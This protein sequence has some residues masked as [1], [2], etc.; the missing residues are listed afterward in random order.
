MQKVLLYT[1][2]ALATTALQPLHAQ[3]PPAPA[4]IELALLPDAPLPFRPP[5]HAAAAAAIMANPCALKPSPDATAS[6]SST[7]PGCQPDPYERFVDSSVPASLTVRQKG[8]LAIHEFRDPANIVTILGTSAATVGFNAHTAYGP[9][10]RGF[11]N[12]VKYTAS[13]DAVVEFFGAFLIP[14]L[15]HEDPRYRRMPHAS[16]PR[17]AL[18]AVAASLIGQ[19]D[20]G[21]RMPNYGNLLTDPICAEISNLYVP[22]VHTNGPSTALRIA[23]GYGTVPADNLI[24][25]FLPDVARHIHIRIIFVQQVL[26]QLS[27]RPDALP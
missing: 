24:S 18:H 22:G 2:F 11:G 13:Q 5:L 27:N 20:G 1:A 19:H 8:L 3:S 25:E 21:T 16:V 12:A 15:T 23:T 26:N 9:G 10:W 6:A 17:R 14:S 4:P 7:I